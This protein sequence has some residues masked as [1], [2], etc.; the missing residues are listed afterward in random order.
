MGRRIDQAMSNLALL[1]A[2]ANFKVP[3]L[4]RYDFMPYEDEPEISMEQAMQQ[5]K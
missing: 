4:S 1:I 2:R 3:D 5:W